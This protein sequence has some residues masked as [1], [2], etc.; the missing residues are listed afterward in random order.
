MPILNL[1]H[2]SLYYEEFGRGDRYLIQ[3]QQFVNSHIYYTKDLADRCGFHAFIIRIR[4]YAPSSMVTEDLGDDWYDVWA[5]DVVDFADAMGIEKFFYTGHSHGAGIGWHLCMNHPD[6]LRGFFASGSGPHLKDGKPTGSARMDTINAAKSRET[7]VPYAEKQASYCAKAFVPLESDP[8]IGGEAKK[9]VEQTVEFWTNMPAQSAVLNPRKPLDVYKRQDLTTIGLIASA[10]SWAAFIIRPF[11]APITDRGNKKL[12]YIAAVGA[13]T[14]AVFMYSLSMDNSAFAVPAKI[15]HG[16]SWTFISTITAVI[17]SEYVPREDLGT[18]MG[19]FMISQM[20]ASA[21]SQPVAFALA[22]YMGYA[23]M[24]LVF[25]AISAFGL[26]LVCFTAP[27]KVP[28][29]LP[30]QSMFGGLKLNNLFAKEA[31]SPMIIN[32]AFRCV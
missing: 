28:A 15:I 23:S 8:V 16:V 10:M 31:I 5:Q 17:V 19:F 14:L 3:A 24:L 26:V 18:A 6:R 12:I 29:R 30:G 4:G 2:V 7:W 1:N 22:E 13:L 20:I 27:T 9:A 21:V 11:S 32:V 25:T